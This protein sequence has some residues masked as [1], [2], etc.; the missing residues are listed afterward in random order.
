[1]KWYVSE[2][3]KL[4]NKFGQ[5]Y[6]YADDECKI[7][8]TGKY[9]IIYHGYLIGDEHIDDVIK[10]DPYKL[11]DANGYYWAIILTQN[12][13]TAIQD[14][15]CHTKIFYR[16]TDTIDVTNCI[17]FFPFTGKDIDILKIQQRLE[18]V[19]KKHKKYKPLETF[20]KLE[21]FILDWQSYSET[22][23]D[24]VPDKF[25]YG[26]KSTARV[27]IRQYQPKM[28][29]TVFHN[30]FILEPDHYLEIK[31]KKANVIRSHDTYQSIVDSLNNTLP[32]KSSEEVEDYIHECM[33]SHAN[34][35]KKTY[36]NIVSSL[37]EGIDSNLVDMYF[38]EAKKIMYHLQPENAPFM[39]KQKVIEKM[40]RPRDIQINHFPLDKVSE[41][42]KNV[43]N[44]PTCFYWDCLPS[45]D[46][47]NRLRTKPD[48]VLFQQGGDNMWMHKK[49]FYY[50]FMWGKLTADKTITGEQKLEK[51]N[52][53]LKE[54][55]GSYSSKNNI[56]D[57]NDMAWQ[58]AFP[59]PI[60][61][62][63]SEYRKQ[64]IREL[65]DD[66][67]DEWKED[68]VKK[69]TPGLYN[70]ELFHCC[71][72]PIISLHSD[73]RIFYTVMQCPE[74]I[75]LSSIKDV[76]IQRNILKRKFNYHFETASKDQA[77]YN[78][79]HMIKSVYIDS[80]KYCLEDHLCQI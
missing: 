56:W 66:G 10:K 38:P 55:A 22:K 19:P 30:T 69:N 5:W 46:Q 51:F 27:G 20:E 54:Y 25:P 39:Y 77:E 48:C 6:W 65:E 76:T 9:L 63:E 80:V 32:Y 33:L 4:A 53:I 26:Y 43:M 7:V 40:P 29:Q 79:V 68:F 62:T 11:K 28:S 75:M 70:R 41:I 24:S 64:L 42:A 21:T 31:N 71:D 3:I 57:K 36:K 45:M 35:I 15:F 18:M 17:Y 47:I 49:F 73:R 14:Y 59:P 13:L 34:I 72:T 60:G 78:A 67:P 74:D 1:M 23:R 37:G 61:V 50:E 12:G 8:D 52:Q 44:D 16:I 58:S 2:K